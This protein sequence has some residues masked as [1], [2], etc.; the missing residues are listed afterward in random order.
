MMMIFISVFM[1]TMPVAVQAL[2]I[3]AVAFISY[4]IHNDYGPFID[5]EMN[6]LE[7]Y[8]LITATIT[9]YGGLYYISGLIESLL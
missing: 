1:V 6:R 2:A 8:A 4:V 3:L 7:K 5:E 9:L